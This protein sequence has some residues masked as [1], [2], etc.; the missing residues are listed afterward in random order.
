MKKRIKLSRENRRRYLLLFVRV[1][2]AKVFKIVSGNK[3]QAAAGVVAVY[4][5]TAK[6]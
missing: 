6:S 4:C 1:A 3:R 2:F 5:L